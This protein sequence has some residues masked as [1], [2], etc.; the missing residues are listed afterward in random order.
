MNTGIAGLFIGRFYLITGAVL[1]LWPYVLQFFGHDLFGNSVHEKP[2]RTE[3]ED[4]VIVKFDRS[5][6]ACVL[7]GPLESRSYSNEDMLGCQGPVI[8]SL[9]W[10]HV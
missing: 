6:R 8:A 3:L 10:E 2:Y 7:I 1:I 4:F 9:P 5:A